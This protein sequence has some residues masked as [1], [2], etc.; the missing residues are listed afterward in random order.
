MTDTDTP[1]CIFSKDIQ[2]GHLP[3]QVDFDKLSRGEIGIIAQFLPLVEH[4]ILRKL[5][6]KSDGRSCSD[7]VVLMDMPGLYLQPQLQSRLLEYV[8]SVVREN[9]NL[10]FIIVTNSSALKD[11][12]N[13][14]ELF[15]LMPS[16]LLVEGSNRLVKVSDPNVCLAHF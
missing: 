14:E 15:M 13:A 6:P 9:E 16:Q 10:Q 4:Q 12:A 2:S 11:K 7:I 3:N 5:V 8:R 1:K